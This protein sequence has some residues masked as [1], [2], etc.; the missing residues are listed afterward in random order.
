[1]RVAVNLLWLVPG[2]VGGSEESTLASLRALARRADWDLEL[3]LLVGADLLEAHPD[4]ATTFPTRVA[5]WSTRS[6]SA[7]LLAE[8]SWLARQTR[9]VDLVHHA[10]GTVPP[11]R[12][13]PCVLTLHDLQPLERR[14][15]HG[16]LKRAYLGVA[17]PRSID[18]A[19]TVVVPSEHVRRGVLDR[20][21]PDPTKVVVVHH[22]VERRTGTGADELRR[23]YDLPGPVVLYP[24]ITYPHKNHR[25]LVEAFARLGAVHPDV[26]LVLTG[27]AG[28]EEG[29]VAAQVERLG[30]AGRVRRP[31]RVP[32]ADV[33]GLYD[34]ATVVAVPSSYEGFGLPAAEALAHGAALVAADATALPEVVGEAGLLVPPDDVDGWATALDRLLADEGERRR[35][36]EA[37]LRRAE[38]FTWAANATALA[39]VYRRAAGA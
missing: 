8:S 15:T 30:I 23:R 14:A 21:A 11:R 27:G 5:P 35:L 2:K 19:R 4:L 17:V 28:S 29:A 34:L 10:G 38:R 6:R 16:R 20:F 39:D 26:V 3:E 37:A 25:V 1:M 7:R 31:G 18:A 33:A 9:S 32:A 22:G 13:A 36:G 12:S 24:A